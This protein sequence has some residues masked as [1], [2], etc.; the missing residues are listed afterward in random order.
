MIL[1]KNIAGNSTISVSTVR[2]TKFI[3][4]KEIVRLQASGNYTRIFIKNKPPMIISKSLKVF[5]GILKPAGF[6]RTQQSHLINP[7]YVRSVSRHQE[8]Q[9][10]DGAVAGISRRKRRAV[11]SLLK[12]GTLRD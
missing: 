10:D 7:R 8:I 6:L 3:C 12:D 1:N 9:M 2:E 4:T 5:D 11:L